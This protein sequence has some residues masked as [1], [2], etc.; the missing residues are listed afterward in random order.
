[1]TTKKRR[2]L[3]AL[4]LSLAML[5]SIIPL[6]VTLVQPVKVAGYGISNPRTDKNGVSTWDCI[7]FGSY[8]QRNSATKELN[9]K[10]LRNED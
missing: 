1:M 2:K 7:Y 3:L 6:Q 4:C 9:N 5:F 8:Y 10:S